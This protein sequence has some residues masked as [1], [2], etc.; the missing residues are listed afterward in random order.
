MKLKSIYWKA[1]DLFDGA[2]FW[3]SPF[4]F[5]YVR[6]WLADVFL[7]SG[8]VS[9]SDWQ[10]N[11]NLFKYEFKVPIVSPEFAAFTST[12]VEL[13]C[14]VMLVLGLGTRLG[15]LAIFFTA[16]VIELTYIHHLDHI[17]WMMASSLLVL[18]G[19]EKISVDYV[20]SKTVF[21]K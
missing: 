5:F 13:I 14:P 7:R 2:D 17:L 4:W 10:N 6:Y 11:V 9:V 15:A 21:K 1:S 3:L 20:L 19:A 12:A 8:L 16:L 18:K